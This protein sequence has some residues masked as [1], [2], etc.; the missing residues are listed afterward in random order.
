MCQKV[1][2]VRQSKQMNIEKGKEKETGECKLWIGKRVEGSVIAQDLTD[3]ESLFDT[4]GDELRNEHTYF[5]PL[6]AV[7]R[8]TGTAHSTDGAC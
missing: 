3:G 4:R 8:C 6:D 7:I 1:R 5:N 2:W